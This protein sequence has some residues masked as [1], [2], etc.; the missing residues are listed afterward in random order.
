[1][2]LLDNLTSGLQNQ[3]NET[4]SNLTN[5]IKVEYLQGQAASAI[6]AGSFG[7]INI[8]YTPPTGYSVAFVNAHATA[9]C[10]AQGYYDI[11]TGKI[12]GTAY[13]NTTVARQPYISLQVLLLKAD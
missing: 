2:A 9:G 5:L 13:N 11:T 6:A 10:I 4:N 12:G 3:V 8:D 1:M 7:E